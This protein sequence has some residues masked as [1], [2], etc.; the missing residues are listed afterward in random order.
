MI[1][2]AALIVMLVIAAPDALAQPATTIRGRVFAAGNRQPL[3]RALVA[4]AVRP[5]PERPGIPLLPPQEPRGVLTDDEGRFEIA[6]DGPT[7]LIASKGGYA[8][9]S[10]DIDRKTIT[11]RTEVAIQL[12]KGAAVSGRLTRSSGEAIAGARVI[13]R[14][15]DA[16]AK[17]GDPANTAAGISDDRGEFRISGLVSG[18]YEVSPQGMASGLREVIAQLSIGGGRTCG[19]PPAVRC[20]LPG[21]IRVPDAPPDPVS[22][23]DLHA[24]DDAGP[25]DFQIDGALFPE[26]P[27]NVIVSHNDGGIQFRRSDTVH[28][29]FAAVITGTVVDQAGEPLQGIQVQSLRL[30]RE[31][32]R[33]VVSDPPPGTRYVSD[34]RGRYRLY[35]L[36]SGTY[37][38]VA[39]TTAKASGLDRERG[40]GF[41]K[42]YYPGTSSLESAQ[43]VRV[44]DG[45]ETGGVDLSYVPTRSA[46]VSGTAVDRSGEPLIGQVR[47]IS[48]QRSGA[49][50]VDPIVERVDWDGTFVFPNV[51]AG[52][53]VLQ[54]V[55][56]NPG[57][58]DEFGYDYVSIA[59]LDP[60]PV[61]ITTSI[62][63][64][65]QGR[66][67][68]DGGRSMA[69][70]FMNLHAAPSDFDRAPAE[71]RGPDGLAIF[72]EGKFSL[73]GLRGSMRL[74]TGDLPAGWYLKSISIGGF[75]L[76]DQPFDFGSTEQTFTDAEVVISPAGA[77]ISGSVED[78][79]RTRA[80]AFTVVAF[81][82]SRDA[83]FAGSRYV[84]QGRA[85]ANGSFTISGL[86]PGDY[87]VT[88][89]DRLESA[90]W[91]TPDVLDALAQGATRVTVE[92]GQIAT[93][94]LRLMRRQ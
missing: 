15:V 52:D 75:D 70:R 10:L 84:K 28:E 38:V 67:I 12:P 79:S 1:R 54:A 45:R 23:I 77:T 81:S 9:A 92:E 17:A 56:T 11:A 14:R 43:I 50:A 72:D 20:P 4:I 7:T 62:G 76:T 27:S 66:F 5:T 73:N 16:D 80:S 18:R 69:M 49:V 35:G 53:Y 61:K 93:I 86:A 87:W 48:S 22:S 71:G 25:V 37:L 74:T 90:D 8:P 31:N 60:D 68:V 89:V 6:I 64:T 34:D 29:R 36:P 46:R 44:D 13:A 40:H 24:G 88:A 91:Q 59:D 57:H 33:M 51:P 30:R 94:G 26:L 65:L 82:R 83:W 47:L 58:R 78:G 32:G 19:L 42:V 41:T 21:D 63:A 55:G 3:R 85:D 2:L 39:S